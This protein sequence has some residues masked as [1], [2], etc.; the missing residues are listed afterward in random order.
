MTE[1]LHAE[2]V[3]AAR[4]GD[5]AAIEE[6]IARFRKPLFHYACSYLGNEADAD[7]VTQEVLIKAVRALPSFKGESA[8]GTWFFRIM[9]NT[10][11]DYRRKT[12]TRKSTSLIRTDEDGAETIL[13]LKDP[14]PLPEQEMETME[15]RATIQMALD[16]LS[17][18]HRAIVVLHDLQGFKYQEIAQ[19]T[20]ANLG[21]V[22]SRLFYARQELRNLLGPILGKE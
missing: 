13:D 21:T 2:I 18:E 15:L 12:N 11:I 8:I 14:R 16:R 10:C 1:P 3:T 5:P 9:V 17:P 4:N 7:D 19:L 6:L 20:G 22:K